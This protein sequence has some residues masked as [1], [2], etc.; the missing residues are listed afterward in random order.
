[1]PFEGCWSHC[2]GEHG[3]ASLLSMFGVFIEFMSENH[4]VETLGA[5]DFHNQIV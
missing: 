1:M 5:G 2:K 4:G 3:N